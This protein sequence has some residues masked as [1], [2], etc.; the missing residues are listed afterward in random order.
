ML[1]IK[2]GY[3]TNDVI[4]DNRFILKEFRNIVNCI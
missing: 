1:K 2:I 4:N 3:L